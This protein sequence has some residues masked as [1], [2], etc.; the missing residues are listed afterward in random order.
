[1]GT[2]V[3]WARRRSCPEPRNNY[4]RRQRLEQSHDGRPFLATADIGEIEA[5]EVLPGSPVRSF[6]SAYLP[7]VARRDPNRRHGCRTPV[8]FT[9][10]PMIHPP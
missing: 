10:E 6:R 8:T 3:P 7:D 9:P 1:M 5:R 4:N 2:L